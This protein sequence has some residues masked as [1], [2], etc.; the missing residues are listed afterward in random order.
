[1]SDS[2]QTPQQVVESELRNVGPIEIV[3]QREEVATRVLTALAERMR[4]EVGP[5]DCGCGGCDHCSQH[6]LID[7][8]DPR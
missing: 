5:L 7:W 6:A 4:S 3:F 2:A 8:L 1:M